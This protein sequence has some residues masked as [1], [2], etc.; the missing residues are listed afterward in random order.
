MN[1]LTGGGT[2]NARSTP[3][4][5]DVMNLSWASAM[6]FRIFHFVEHLGLLTP[7]GV[8]KISHVFY[9]HLVEF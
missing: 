2:H 3:E 4:M 9:F 8:N 7:S 5:V 6:Y 1:Y